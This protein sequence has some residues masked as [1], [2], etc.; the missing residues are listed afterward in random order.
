MVELNYFIDELLRDVGA[1][2]QVQRDH[3]CHL[4]LVNLNEVDACVGADNNLVPLTR[5]L[6]LVDMTDGFEAFTDVQAK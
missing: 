2:T 6:H 5:R 4:I 3:A 1:W